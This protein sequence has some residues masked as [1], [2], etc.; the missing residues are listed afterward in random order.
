MR[1]KQKSLEIR[2]SK[3]PV[4]NAFFK[5]PKEVPGL[6]VIFPGW[7][8][9]C[10]YPILHYA[11]LAAVAGGVDVLQVNYEYNT[12]GLRVTDSPSPE[13]VAHLAGDVEAAI[14]AGLAQGQYRRVT[15]LGKSFGTRAIAHLLS[16]TSVFG[17]AS[18]SAVWLTPL[19]SEPPVYERML[20]FRGESLA[21][22]GTRDPYYDDAK[23]NAVTSLP[24]AKGMLVEEGDHSL[25]VEDEPVRSLEELKRL[26]TAIR[27]MVA[28]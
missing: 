4:P 1:T 9:N 23:W 16:D 8:Y 28:K 27:A 26:T 12:K 24:K 25:E 7:Q 2:T 20:A 11:T 17:S 14:E 5:Q 6:A 3:G 22:I 19:L 10:H 18:V 21:V 15:L 13:L